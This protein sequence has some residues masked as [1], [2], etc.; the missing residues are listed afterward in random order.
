MPKVIQLIESEE[1]LCGNG[2]DTDPYRR[3]ISYY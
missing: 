3:V 2:K 1:I